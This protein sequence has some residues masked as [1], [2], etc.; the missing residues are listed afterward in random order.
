MRSILGIA[1]GI[2]ILALFSQWIRL[3]LGFQG[4]WMSPD[5]TANVVA[6]VSFAEHGTFALPFELVKSFPWAVPRSFVAMVSQGQIVPVGFLGM[7]LVLAGAFKLAGTFG[8]ILFTPLIALLTLWAL[9]QILPKAWPKI[10]RV[11]ALLVWMSFPTVIIYA[12]RGAFANLFITC[13]AIWIWWLLTKA[14]GFWTWP[15]AGALLGLACV[16][17][18]PEAVWLLPLAVFAILYNKH[19]V[20][21]RS[22]SDEAISGDCRAT[23]NSARND[24]VKAVV[25]GVVFALMLLGGAYLGY[26]TYGHWLASGY[27]IR[28]MTTVVSDQTVQQAT[29]KA[30]SI[31][32]IQPLAT[33]PK[34]M[35]WNAWKYLGGILWP[36][37]L[38]GILSLGLCIQKRVWTTPEKWIMAGALWTFV[39]LVGFYGNGLY[40]DH[41]GTNIPSMG[42]SYLRYLLPLS[43]MAAVG[44]GYLVNELWKYWSLRTMAV[45]LTA[46]LVFV[47]LWDASARDDEGMLANQK[48]FFRYAA[49]RQQARSMLAP[50]TVVLSDRSDKIFF[51]VFPAVSPMP[52][53]EDIV[54]LGGKVNV[55]LFMRTINDR[56]ASD[57]QSKGIN[58]VPL[59]TSNNESLYD[60]K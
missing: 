14:K 58:L 47:G 12:N 38:M 52:K 33:H 9:W 28:P 27:Q 44:A 30:V 56:E 55:A 13:L 2:L 51:P 45:V 19:L 25:A 7:P 35:L 23:S 3:P 43:V 22:S 48:E 16:I 53:P 32:S 17:R 24:K 36:W 39:W 49:I 40:Q 21:A 8:V 31:F 1:A 11:S 34:S 4:V 10:A 59:F 29:S 20:I 26:K 6:G 60:V 18:P 42:N 5:E 15:M 41:V 57:W 46:F 50:G 37:T 54:A